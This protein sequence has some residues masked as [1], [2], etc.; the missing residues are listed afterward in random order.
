MDSNQTT[1][2]GEMTLITGIGRSIVS[3]S[4]ADQ[5]GQRRTEPPKRNEDDQTSR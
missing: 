3:R 1:A 4:A 2:S 5:W